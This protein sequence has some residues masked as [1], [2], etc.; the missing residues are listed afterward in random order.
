[1]NVNANKSL[2]QSKILWSSMASAGLST[3]AAT[4]SAPD[5]VPTLALKLL[6]AGAAMASVAAATFR[7][8]DQAT[9]GTRE[10]KAAP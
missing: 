8:M 7:A 1:V 6:S 9:K 2:L 3:L 10:H 4:L 5:D